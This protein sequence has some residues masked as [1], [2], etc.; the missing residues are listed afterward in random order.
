MIEQKFHKDYYLDYINN[1]RITNNIN[2]PLSYHGKIRYYVPYT[3]VDYQTLTRLD[4]SNTDIEILPDLPNL[5]FLNCSKTNIKQL[6]LLPNLQEL[7]CPYSEITEIPNLQNLEILNISFCKNIRTIPFLQNLRELEALK[8]DIEDIPDGMINLQRVC[9]CD[10]KVKT[11]PS[12]LPGVRSLL[13]HRTSVREIPENAFYPLL[14]RLTIWK[15][16]IEEIPLIPSI[17]YMC[18]R[19][20]I[21]LEKIASFPQLQE[22][23]LSG[24]KKIKCLPDMPSLTKLYTDDT[25]LERLSEFPN[26]VYLNI[27]NNSIQITNFDSIPNT[28]KIYAP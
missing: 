22:L 11:L 25:A 21:Y 10:T 17:T 19:E 14:T 8:S 13:F 28:C 7:I 26:L 9:V 1:L 5:V 4:C 18:L 12:F 3:D 6:P 16:C 20:N 15:T 23:S 2:V 24:S 27:I